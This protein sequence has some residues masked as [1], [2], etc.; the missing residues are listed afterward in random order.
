MDIIKEM[1]DRGVAD[2]GTI[3][4]PDG[5]HGVGLEITKDGEVLK[6]SLASKHPITSPRD[7]DGVAMILKD[8]AEE[9]LAS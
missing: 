4:V 9:K 1:T 5:A 3:T 6:M 8:W 2:Y 7:L